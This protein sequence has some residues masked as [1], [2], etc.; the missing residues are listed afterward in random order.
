MNDLLVHVSG[1]RLDALARNSFTTAVSSVLCCS[2][3]TSRLVAQR[4]ICALFTCLMN[5]LSVF[6]ICFGK[7]FVDRLTR[8]REQNQRCRIRRLQAEGLNK[9]QSV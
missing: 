7:S 6:S 5:C 2:S 9:I 8:L 3:V 1:Q 4:Q